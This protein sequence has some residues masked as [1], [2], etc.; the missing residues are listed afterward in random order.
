MSSYQNNPS[1][2]AQAPAPGAATSPAAPGSP[3]AGQGQPTPG[4]AAMPPPIESPLLKLEPEQLQ[5]LKARGIL[6]PEAVQ[7]IEMR[8]AEAQTQRSLPQQA[9]LRAPPARVAQVDARAGVSQQQGFSQM[10]KPGQQAPQAQAQAPTKKARPLTKQQM[11]TAKTWESLAGKLNVGPNVIGSVQRRDD[12]LATEGPQQRVSV[13]DIPLAAQKLLAEM[14]IELPKGGTSV[15]NAKDLSPQEKAL[16]AQLVVM[17][18]QEQS[19]TRKAPEEA[20]AKKPVAQG[21]R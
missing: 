18:K 13:T 6:S 11:D 21:G 7:V 17:G 8:R 16:L 3:A 12:P 9:Q 15:W 14:G 5:L 10:F 4:R 20:P 2:P 1:A 19:R